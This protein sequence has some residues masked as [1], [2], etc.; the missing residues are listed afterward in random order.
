VFIVK[1]NFT[2]S[3]RDFRLDLLY[4]NGVTKLFPEGLEHLT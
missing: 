4:I 3:F 1:C 2:F